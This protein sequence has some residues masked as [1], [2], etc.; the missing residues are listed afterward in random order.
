MRSI[1]RSA[2]AISVPRP[3]PISISRTVSGWPW[4]CQACTTNIPISSPN[5]WLISGA[6]VKSPER[7]NGSRER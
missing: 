7:P 5:S 4:P 1:V 2:S 6:V 3:G